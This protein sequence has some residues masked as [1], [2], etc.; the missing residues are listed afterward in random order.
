[1]DLNPNPDSIR[2][3]EAEELPNLVVRVLGCYPIFLARCPIINSEFGHVLLRAGIRLRELGNPDIIRPQS[4]GI[5]H[6][7]LFHYCYLVGD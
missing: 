3:S 5:I 7:W 1:M 4:R 2:D 6:V